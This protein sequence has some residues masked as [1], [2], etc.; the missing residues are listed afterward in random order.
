MLVKPW[1]VSMGGTN[2]AAD[3]GRGLSNVG[4][5]LG[6]SMSSPLSWIISGEGDGSVM[7]LLYGALWGRGEISM[8]SGLKHGAESGIGGVVTSTA[9]RVSL[10]Y[11]VSAMHSHLLCE[12]ESIW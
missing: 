10:M 9:G 4:I 11:R 3:T 12:F 6:E 2:S 5:S 7:K 1:Y 8:E